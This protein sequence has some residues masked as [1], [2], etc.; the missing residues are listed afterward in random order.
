MRRGIENFGAEIAEHDNRIKEDYNALYHGMSTWGAAS[1]PEQPG[2]D[3][4]LQTLDDMR[5]LHEAYPQKFQTL[6]KDGEKKIHQWERQESIELAFEL[7]KPAMLDV[8]GFEKLGNAHTIE[9]PTAAATKAISVAE[10][11]QNLPHD[12]RNLKV[13][14]PIRT[15]S[16]PKRRN[17]QQSGSSAQHAISPRLWRW[18]I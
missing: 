5:K 10:A 17:R 12:R 8:A 18:N 7:F 3:T 9:L 2:M 15:S 1:L 11:I 16:S 6:A 14:I 4:Q 13:P